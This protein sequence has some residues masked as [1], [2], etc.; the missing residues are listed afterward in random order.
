MQGGR[1]GSYRQRHS[2]S[3]NFS[4]IGPAAF[5]P[6]ILQRIQSSN[7]IHLY[8]STNH[9]D[10]L[11]LRVSSFHLHLRLP[12]LR[13]TTQGSQF[14]SRYTPFQYLVTPKKDCTTQSST[15]SSSTHSTNV[16]ISAPRLR[17]RRQSQST[18]IHRSLTCRSAHVFAMRM[19]A[20][21]REGQ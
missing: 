11:N 12:E 20:S 16:L 17:S 14:R 1:G 9:T 8:S 18:N 2:G 19:G 15:L 13:R 3:Q 10:L 5:D 7:S 21:G 6:M 4:I